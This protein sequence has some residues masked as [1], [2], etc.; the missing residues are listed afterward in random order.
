[1]QLLVCC[2]W[3][4]K[5]SS[6]FLH[7][8]NKRE[9]C[10]LQYENV[11]VFIR[12]WNIHTYG[13]ETRFFYFC[14]SSFGTPKAHFAQARVCAMPAKAKSFQLIVCATLKGREF[15]ALI[16]MHAWMI[17]IVYVH[18]YVFIYE[19]KSKHC[20]A[21]HYFNERYICILWHMKWLCNAP[22]TSWMKDWLSFVKYG[23]EFYIDDC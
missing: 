13:D 18:I 7:Q 4:K 20:T 15:L 3:S 23:N 16:R 12:P 19:Q 6:K 17:R 10:K 14:G 22:S 5:P 9:K 21:F 2:F 1:M 8:T 11:H